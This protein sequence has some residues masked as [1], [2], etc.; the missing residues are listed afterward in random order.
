MEK[1]ILALVTTARRLPTI[2]PGSHYQS[3]NRTPNETDTAQAKDLGKTDK[4]GH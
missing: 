4:M 2:F 1:L 3:L